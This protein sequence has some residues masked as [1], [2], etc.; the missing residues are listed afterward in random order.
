MQIR[1]KFKKFLRDFLNKKHFK[2]M[3]NRFIDKFNQK[4]TLIKDN[5]VNFLIH[6]FLRKEIQME[7]LEIERKYLVNSE[8]IFLE[9]YPHKKIIQGYI[10]D[11]KFTEIRIK[12]SRK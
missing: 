8:N 1:K 6:A 2:N 10:Y 9:R 3:Y 7:N 11:E 12:K 5:N 4:Y